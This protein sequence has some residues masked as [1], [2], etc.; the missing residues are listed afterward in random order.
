MSIPL[1][2]LYHFIDQT[3][4]NIYGEPVIIYRFWPHG[5][6]NINDLNPLD[7]IPITFV[8]RLIKPLLWCNDQEPLNYDYY[9]QNL[10]ILGGKFE[11]FKSLDMVASITNLAYQSNI[12][13]KNLLLHSE[14]RSQDEK[15]YAAE[16][17]LIPV[18]Y[19]SH[20]LIARDWFRFAQHE[21][22][23]KNTHNLFLIYNR[24]WSGTREYRLKFLDMLIENKLTDQCQTFFNPIDGGQHY[25]D[26]DLVNPAWMPKHRP[27]RF[28][29]PSLAESSASA[30]FNSCDYRNTDIEVVLET[31]FDDDRLHLTEKTL[32]PIACGQP[33]ILAATH[34]S[35]QYLREYGFQTFESVWDE[36]YDQIQDPYQRMLAIIKVMRDISSWST[37]KRDRNLEQLNQIAKFNQNHFFSDQFQLLII[38]ELKE[39]LTCAF[40]QIKTTPGFERWLSWYEERITNS[41][42][43]KFLD[44]NQDELFPTRKGYQQVLDYIE[45]YS[46][47]SQSNN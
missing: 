3:A 31:L 13:K 17:R 28:F 4:R 7:P 33:F 30:D 20:A 44:T 29:Q 45:N 47:E 23:K 43:Q 21:N 41:A 42:L 5:S 12:F 8:N 11:F 10:R 1:D 40:E 32:R 14:K 39:N 38:S 6:K 19:W 36:S 22:F 24:A 35:L 2:R 15:K 18:Y 16:N 46:K 26:Y 25:H 9:R 27:E 37:Q 34:G